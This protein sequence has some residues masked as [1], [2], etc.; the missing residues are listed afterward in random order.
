MG[1]LTGGKRLDAG[2][3]EEPGLAEILRQQFRF[4][5]PQAARNGEEESAVA[6]HHVMGAV[7]AAQS[8]ATDIDGV[9]GDE[10]VMDTDHMACRRH[11]FHIVGLAHAARHAKGINRLLQRQPQ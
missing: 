8:Q 6:H 4:R 9:L 3:G 1:G 7:N 10:A 5:W 2:A 11:G